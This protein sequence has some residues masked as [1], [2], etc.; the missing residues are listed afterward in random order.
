MSRQLN[1]LWYNH[2]RLDTQ[3]N[4]STGRTWQWQYVANFG[5]SAFNIISFTTLEEQV[6]WDSMLVSTTGDRGLS[7]DMY[8]GGTLSGEGAA[9]QGFPHNH[10][11]TRAAPITN[12]QSGGIV[13]L[14]GTLIA[15][16]ILGDAI[17]GGND[18]GSPILRPSTVYYWEVTNL[19]NQAADVS[20]LFSMSGLIGKS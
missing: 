6:S 7:L 17:Q 5:A 11:V 1:D 10:D 3:F 12:V 14:G 4:I 20:L 9:V 19:H 13:L 2:L 15:Q 8:V 16:R 18:S